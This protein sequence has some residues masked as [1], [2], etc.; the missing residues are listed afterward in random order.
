M[1]WDMFVL[2]TARSL[3]AVHEH[4][5]IWGPGSMSQLVLWEM[6]C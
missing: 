5:H 6:F 4:A 1:L 3:C 2:C